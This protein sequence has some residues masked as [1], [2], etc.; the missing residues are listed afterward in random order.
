MES[1]SMQNRPNMTSLTR[2]SDILVGFNFD[3][4]QAE[5]NA[6][7]EKLKPEFCAKYG[8]QSLTDEEAGKIE[9]AEFQLKECVDCSERFCNKAT[10]KFRRPLITSEDGKLKIETVLCDVWLKE[11]YKEQCQLSGIPMKYATLTFKDYTVTADNE[12]A[13][14]LAQWFLSDNRQKG[15]YFYGGAGTGKTFL[16]SLIARE[17]VLRSKDVVFGDVPLLLNELKRAFNNPTQ[18][19]EEVLERYCRSKLLILDDLGAG[20]VTDWTVGILYQ[21]VN[22]RYNDGKVIIVTSNY[23][24]SELEKQ[25]NVS[26][27][28][29]AKRIVSRLAEMCYQGFLGTLDRR[30]QS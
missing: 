11:C 26:D 13:V 4:W 15:L 6:R 24:L 29:S 17:Y 8:L 21:I 28:F 14:K 20:Q 12:Q 22:N 1:T 27:E 9:Y 23:D 25:L 18:S 10:K 3:Q 30:K 5:R 16:A 2:L 19:A 7:R